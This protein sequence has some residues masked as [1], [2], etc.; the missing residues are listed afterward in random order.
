MTN[1]NDNVTRVFHAFEENPA[2]MNDLLKGD[3]KEVI[4]N[5][6]V[7][8]TCNGEKWVPAKAECTK[9][10]EEVKIEALTLLC[11]DGKWTIKADKA[12]EDGKTD[13]K[14]F[15]GVEITS[16]CVDGAWVVDVPKTEEKTEAA[17]ED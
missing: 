14:T 17:E 5:S 9:D 10:N 3:E 6:G 2:A 11:D 13:K 16:T 7:F 1:T 8:V 12:C 4:K 15:P